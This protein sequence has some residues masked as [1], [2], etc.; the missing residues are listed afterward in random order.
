MGAVV[1]C[2]SLGIPLTLPLTCPPSPSHTRTRARHQQNQVGRNL[3]GADGSIAR[4]L[5]I[6]ADWPDLGAANRE[7][8]KGAVA[9][10][11]CQETVR[12]GHSVLMFCASKAGCKVSETER[13]RR[14]RGGAEA[15]G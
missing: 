8:A 9:A 10:W 14:S 12:D 2:P 15:V 5:A 6:P 7:A 4:Q 3:V 11:L 1:L 13:E